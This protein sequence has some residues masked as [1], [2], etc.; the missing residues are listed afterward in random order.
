MR[1]AVTEDKALLGSNLSAGPK[2]AGVVFGLPLPVNP[3]PPVPLS[4]RFRADQREAG[5]SPSS[6]NEIGFA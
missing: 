3:V 2:L 6:I 4:A 5:F 1:S